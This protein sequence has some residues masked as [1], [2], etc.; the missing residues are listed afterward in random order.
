MFTHIKTNMTFKDRKEAKKI[1]GHKNYNKAVK[2]HEF[3]FH[4]DR[5]INNNNK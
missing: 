5:I 3:T 2:N 4:D 1:M